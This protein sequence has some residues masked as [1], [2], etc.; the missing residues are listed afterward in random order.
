VQPSREKSKSD[1]GHSLGYTHT[2]CLRML[3]RSRAL[4]G[5]L[6]QDAYLATAG[7]VG[8]L[9]EIYTPEYQSWQVSDRRR[10]RAPSSLIYGGDL[11]GTLLA[12]VARFQADRDWYTEMGPFRTAGATCCTGRPETARAASPP[13]WRAWRA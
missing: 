13:P 5:P 9:T 3:G 4:I 11:L 7:A 2:L 8:G 1:S 10:S 6:L 12:D